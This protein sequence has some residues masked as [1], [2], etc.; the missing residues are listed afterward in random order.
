[1]TYPNSSHM[2]SVSLVICSRNR[3]SQLQSCLQK[4]AIMDRPRG[5]ELVVV[6]NGSTDSTA[7]V[8]G[9]FMATA[10]FPVRL[11]HES[12]PGLAIARNSGWRVA[13]GEI[14]AFTDDDCY[15]HRDFA[16]AVLGLFESR[17]MLGF[18]GGRILLHDP[19]DLRVTILVSEEM[20]HF[21]PLSMIPAGAIQGANFAFRRSALE[22]A[23]GFDPL[24]GAGTPYPS[25]DIEMVS[26]LSSLGWEGMYS[27]EPIVYHHHGRKIQADVDNLMR[28]YDVGRGAYYAALLFRKNM[29][30]KTIKYWLECVY[31]QNRQR[32]FNECKGFFGYLMNKSICLHK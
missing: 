23:G 8:V 26:R 15:V 3:A 11:I 18:L 24:L 25:E 10:D 20:K 6:D 9:K 1:M 17:P 27:P 14:V 22:Q 19:D 28:G 31:K 13:T 30:F 2:S 29:R 21:R 32:S 7:E 5:F 12:S 16:H 4:V